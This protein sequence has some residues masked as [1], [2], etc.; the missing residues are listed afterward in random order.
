VFRYSAAAIA[1]LVGKLHVG[2]KRGSRSLAV[3]AVAL[4]LLVPL[5]LLVGSVSADPASDLS[6]AESRVAGAEADVS[7]AQ[8]QLDRASADYDSAAKRAEQP[9]EAARSAQA[10]VREIRTELATEQ[11]DARAEIAGL[12]E[13][14]SEEE[15]ERD[16]AVSSG[17]GIALA[18]LVAAAIALSWGWFRAS[19]IVAPLVRMQL[20]Q[21]VAICVGG[22]FLLLVIGAALAGDGVAGAIGT[23]LV[24]LAF[25]LPTAL[26]LGRHSLEVER[27]EAKPQFGRK[28]MPEW[29]PRTTAGIFLLLFLTGLSISLF[30]DEPEA[31]SPSAELSRE[32]EALERGP[33]AV[34]LSTAK[35]AAARTR[36]RAAN[37]LAQRAS[38]RADLRGA[39]RGLR[40]AE[41]DLAAAEADEQRSSR[42]L[43]SA[44]KAEERKAQEE[45]EREQ[46]RIEEEEDE[47]GEEESA[48]CESGYSP[49]VPS[50]PP[51][52]DCADVAGSVTVT[53]SDPHGLD[54][55]GDGIGCE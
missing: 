19:P 53:G 21:A 30:A 52:V 33:G 17:I 41:A 45:A 49:C 36:E 39:K 6:E 40:G 15:E 27:D 25:I 43:K 37:P 8:Q 7:A 35:A 26:L 5:V 38:A 24:L 16:E 46:R 29:V 4:G 28:R 22:G 48:G 23:A 1:G 55:D 13:A 14:R 42:R 34:R 2:G 50:Y 12:E 18:A 10:E 31:A 54:A 3:L 44:L 20:A 11:R 9:A 32:A 51:D 47:L